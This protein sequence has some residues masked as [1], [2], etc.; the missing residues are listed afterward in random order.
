MAENGANI[1]LTATADG[2]LR[3]ADAVKKKFQEVG[4]QGGKAGQK[5][6]EHLGASFLR[7]AALTQAIRGIAE[8][9]NTAAGNAAKLS[10]EVGGRQLNAELAGSRIGLKSNQVSALMNA[11]GTKSQEE[12]SS[13]ISS[14]SE[15]KGPGG[16]QIDSATA[17]E[18][19][20]LF[21]NGGATQGQ[22]SEAIGKGGR[23]ALKRLG[24]TANA[25]IA[26]LS[27]AAAAE[28]QARI[29]ESATEIGIADTNGEAGLAVRAREDRL[30]LLRAQDPGR[31]AIGD[32]VGAATEHLGGR[33]VIEAGQREG[34][35][36]F[37]DMVGVMRQIAG[38]TSQ[39]LNA[40]AN[41]PER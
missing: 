2:V 14:L 7:A 19:F 34:L 38:N 36:S 21:N 5:M 33:A 18:A 35:G 40:S 3:A 37:V 16:R 23:G 31:F 12:R 25:S 28:R 32:A 24:V 17:I 1:V 8:A 26:G 39:R 10:K 41:G 27:Q 30:R 22:I 13:F 9:F 15:M 29:E 6:F 20:S 11:T 4:E